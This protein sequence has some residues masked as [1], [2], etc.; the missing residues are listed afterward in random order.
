MPVEHLRGAGYSARVLK[1]VLM[2]MLG[3]PAREWS[4]RELADPAGFS[5]S[6]VRVACGDLYS[7]GHLRYRLQPGSRDFCRAAKLY[8]LTDAGTVEWGGRLARTG[9]LLTPTT[10]LSDLT[11]QVMGARL[12]EVRRA[13]TDLVGYSKGTLIL[14]MRAVLRRPAR[15]WTSDQLSLA[16][17]IST[18]TVLLA[19]HDLVAA[20]HLDNLP[21]AL[22]RDGTPTKCRFRLT[23]NGADAWGEV[24]ELDG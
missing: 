17:T 15:M 24:F 12:P 2:P 21:L 18:C 11:A 14:V 23:S 1:A 10:P 19:C 20:G 16:T 22:R 4:I 3:V 13:R 5:Y 6:P 7:L 8:R 9:S